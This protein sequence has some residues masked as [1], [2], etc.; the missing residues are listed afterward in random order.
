MLSK[1]SEV[2]VEGD[3]PPLAGEGDVP[4]L[5]GVG[6]VPPLAGVGDV[7]PLFVRDFACLLID[8]NQ[9]LL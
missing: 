2:D 6:D 3:V 9:L 8:H 7:T 4:P 5:A 1:L